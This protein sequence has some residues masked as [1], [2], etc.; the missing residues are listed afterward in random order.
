MS[1]KVRSIARARK[2]HDAKTGEIQVSLNQLIFCATQTEENP[3]PS[4]GVLLSQSLPIRQAFLLGKIAKAVG[5]EIEQYQATR[6]ALCERYANKDGE[7]KAIM[8]GADDKPVAEGQPGRYD[9]P[10]ESMEAFNKEHAELVATEVSIPGTKIKVNDLAG[11]KIA[12][13][14]LISL[15]WLIDE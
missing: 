10:I 6:K 12:P 4:L 8:L 3:F 1:N 11:V 14:H 13:V 7:G 9:I 2:L 15:E 5:G